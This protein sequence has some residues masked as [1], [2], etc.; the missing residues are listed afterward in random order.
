MRRVA[1]APSGN[2]RSGSILPLQ[3]RDSPRMKAAPSR[4]A[5]ISRNAPRLCG[6]LIV[7]LVIARTFVLPQAVRSERSE[8][9]DAFHADK[10]SCPRWYD[11]SSGATIKL[12]RGDWK[13]GK[14]HRPRVFLY[15]V[16]GS[17][18]EST[19]L[20]KHFLDF[21]IRRAGIAPERIH[22]TVHASHEHDEHAQTLQSLLDKNSVHYD[23]WIGTFTSET[24]AWHR[25]KLTQKTLD[26]D[27]W[28]VVADVD[29]LHQFPGVRAHDGSPTVDTPT[30]GSPPVDAFLAHVAERG[31]NY[32]LA[33]WEDRVAEGGHLNH[34][35]D[36][37]P[38]E[39]QFP[40]RCRMTEWTTPEKTSL[41]TSFLPK[42][43]DHKVIASRNYLKVHRSAHKIRWASY[44]EA[45][46]TFGRVSWP[47]VYVPR[48]H[49]GP[50][51][52]PVSASAQ[53]M[54][55]NHVASTPST[56][57]SESLRVSRESRG[58]AGEPLDTHKWD[59]KIT[60]PPRRSSRSTTSGS[61]AW[62]PTW[63]V[64]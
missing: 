59:P 52:A 24:K 27:D 63:I 60:K 6:F 15:S 3:R 57:P 36:K 30:D 7:L 26:K 23:L 11:Q 50:F 1:S 48:S 14:H 49:G 9:P 12:P 58:S 33:A 34:I 56:W 21:Y 61:R 37:I 40:L 29:E 32:V 42:A 45:I 35:Q 19:R 8:H 46:F 5:R 41:I 18:L 64:E 17:S 31:A 22:V 54:I 4:W 43:E 51:T 38:L 47:T 44:W 10:V 20:A 25:D 2:L 39:R 62:C 13:V 55:L 53:K 28:L 16:F